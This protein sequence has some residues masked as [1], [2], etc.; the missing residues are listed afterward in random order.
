MSKIKQMNINAYY[1]N[2]FV[3]ERIPVTGLCV[4]TPILSRHLTARIRERKIRII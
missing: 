2:Q 3:E 4:A 1:G